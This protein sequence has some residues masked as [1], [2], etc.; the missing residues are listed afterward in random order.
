MRYTYFMS[1]MPQHSVDSRVY[2]RLLLLPHV[3]DA[4]SGGDHGGAEGSMADA[5]TGG[6]AGPQV[7]D[8]VA[9]AWC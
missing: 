9:D 4:V 8:G 2:T 5:P 1:C 6:R 7:D 3:Y